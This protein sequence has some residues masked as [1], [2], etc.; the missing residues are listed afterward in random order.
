MKFE[1]IIRQINGDI[2]F[3]EASQ[4]YRLIKKVESDGVCICKR[5]I[6]KMYLY[7]HDD[8]TKDILILG[9]GCHKT[10]K[11]K[12]YF[13]EKF[14]KHLISTKNIIVGQNTQSYNDLIE[15]MNIY[16]I[17]KCKY[18]NV[19]FTKYQYDYCGR[20][21]NE[22]NCQTCNNEFKPRYEKEKDCKDCYNKK[23]KRICVNCD[24][25]FK[26][27]FDNQIICIGC[28]KEYQ[29]WDEC[30][31]CERTIDEKYFFCYKCNKKHLKK[32]S[33]KNI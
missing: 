21:N 6:K 30:L 8:P 24:S 32:I 9:S 26:F 5:S 27:K 12:G 14:P 10:L 17:K 20:C 16:K 28:Y 7:Q 18:C 23:T 19:N 31:T 2:S 25:L 4:K 1:D 13:G 29:D 22:I 11:E 3:E 15:Q 33:H